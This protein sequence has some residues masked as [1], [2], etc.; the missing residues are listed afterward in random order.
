MFKMI[1]MDA[2][3]LKMRM[4]MREKERRIKNVEKTS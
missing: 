4:R 1:E 2:F 3:E